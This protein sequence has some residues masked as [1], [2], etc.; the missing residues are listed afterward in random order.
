MAIKNIKNNKNNK[1]DNKLTHDLLL[2]DM[3]EA[4]LKKMISDLKV[5]ITKLRLEKNAGKLQNLKLIFNSRK[6]LARVFT[7]LMLKS[8]S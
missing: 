5:K 3:N 1:S 6:Q 7:Q 4:E 8:A 2:A